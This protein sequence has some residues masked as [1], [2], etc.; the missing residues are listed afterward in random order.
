M[1]SPTAW[2]VDRVRALALALEVRIRH[3]CRHAWRQQRPEDHPARRAGEEPGPSA[4][5]TSANP[6]RTR[7]GLWLNQRDSDAGGDVAGSERLSTV[8]GAECAYVAAALVQAYMNTSEH[9]VF[10]CFVGD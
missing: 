5:G 1:A 2:N 8:L 3:E 4:E 7:F 10:G 9:A 6:F